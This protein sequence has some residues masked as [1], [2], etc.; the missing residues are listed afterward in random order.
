MDFDNLTDKQ[1]AFCKEYVMDWNATQAAIRAG[2][3]DNGAGQ[4]AHNLLKNTEI[5]AYIEHIQQDIQQLIGISKASNALELLKIAMKS[6]ARDADRIKAREVVNK[7]LGFN[8]PEKREDTLEIKP[9]KINFFEDE[10]ED[11]TEDS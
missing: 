8:E 1:K 2:Y 11:K 7:M 3:S 4:T 10:Q 6:D 5:R 9:P